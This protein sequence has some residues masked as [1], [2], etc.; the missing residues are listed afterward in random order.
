MTRRAL[1][2][3]GSHKTGTT[4]LQSNLLRSERE[5]LLGRW[6]YLHAQQ[7]VD[8]N[9]FVGVKGMGKDTYPVL[10]WPFFDR[11]MAFAAD[12]G[13]QDVI[14]STEMLFW[15]DT[16]DQIASVYN[17]LQE[18]FDE[19][20]VVAYLRRQDTLA[21]SH[22]KQVVMGRAAYQ[23]YGAQLQSLPVYRPHMMRYFD[24]ATKLSL[25]EEI[26]G[27]Q[28]VTVRRF[29]RH[30]LIGGDTVADFWNL[31]GE[32]LKVQL[33]RKNV[34]WTRTQLKAGL[35]L[36]QRG[37]PRE[38]FVPLVRKLEDPVALMP[39]RADAWAFLD[40]FRD[41]NHRL[42]QRY[43]P[44]GP[45]TYFDMDFSRYPEMDNWGEGPEVDLERLEAAVKARMLMQGLEH[46][47]C[48][49]DDQRESG[50]RWWR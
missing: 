36:R 18:H 8:F 49:P 46:D 22:R 41:S 25:W 6:R 1:L 28:N 27:A 7:R 17:R 9:T 30:D 47:A 34:A 33:E 13:M 32:P 39:A 31:L 14:I 15:L 5:G 10:K 21:L 3:I 40:H 19:I 29:Q 24:Y 38:A 37:Y 48:N 44:D 4:S 16:A 42:A 26:F 2:H 23:F 11:R 45:E 50:P 43:D 12:E 20:H 35:W